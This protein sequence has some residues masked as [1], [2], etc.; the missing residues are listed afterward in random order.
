MAHLDRR[1]DLR[2]VRAVSVM[3]RNHNI[4]CGVVFSV[5]PPG[6]IVVPYASGVGDSHRCYC[7]ETCPMLD[8]HRRL[9]AVEKLI[10]VMEKL[11]DWLRG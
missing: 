8:I 2:E 1:G 6:V 11:D 9:L 4:N 10:P 7:S 3:V 5:P